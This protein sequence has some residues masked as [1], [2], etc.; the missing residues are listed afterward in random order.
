MQRAGVSPLAREPLTATIVAIPTTPAGPLSYLGL[1]ELAGR[2]IGR[3]GLGSPQIK[4]FP[5]RVTEKYPAL[6]YTSPEEIAANK[7][8]LEA[9]RQAARTRLARLST[10]K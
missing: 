4:I 9:G 3:K 10:A 6:G 7:K 5:K 2:A 1:R 8:R